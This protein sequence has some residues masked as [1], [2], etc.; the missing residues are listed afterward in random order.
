MHEDSWQ[1]DATH[2][3]WLAANTKPSVTGQD[4]AIWRRI[5]LIPFL[6]QFTPPG[7][8]GPDRDTSLRKNLFADERPGI[9]TWML[10]GCLSW[11][12]DGLATPPEV[13]AATAN[14]KA[15]EDAVQQFIDSEC[16][17]GKD[18]WE[19]AGVLHKAYQKWA[20]QTRN[21]SLSATALGTRLA[22]KGFKGSRSTDGKTRIRVGLC[23]RNSES[24]K[25]GF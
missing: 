7:E 1:F 9:L 10:E 14:Y 4:Y 16:V 25:L 17:I 23:L 22:K 3:I 2:K 18:L 13:R 21:R 19:D 6:V 15:E 24:E 11:Q 5:K 12:T 20:Q 8:P